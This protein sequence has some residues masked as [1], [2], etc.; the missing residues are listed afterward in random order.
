MIKLLS[1]AEI[2]AIGLGTWKSKPGQ[3]KDAIKFALEVGYRHID[4]AAVYGNE[5][6]IGE[7]LKE[8]FAANV[9]KREELFVTSKLWNT[10]H[11]WVQALASGGRACKPKWPPAWPKIS[12]YSLEAECAELLFFNQ[13][14]VINKGSEK[15]AMH[16]A[17][18]HSDWRPNPGL[19]PSQLALL[20]DL[21]Y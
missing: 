8:A 15:L 20:A 11:R 5:K 1:G 10:K 3:V 6:E 16:F 14:R 18:G 21:A 2:P 12:T 9:I 17:W 13:Q 4:C 7:A 19:L